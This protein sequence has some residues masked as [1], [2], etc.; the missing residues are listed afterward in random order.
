MKNGKLEELD[1]HRVGT[2]NPSA[3]P[4]GTT[5]IAAKSSRRPFT[6]GDDKVLWKWVK[7]AET[8]GLSTK[9]NEIYKSLADEVL[10]CL[11]SLLKRPQS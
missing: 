8:K 9:G 2:M 1:D 7:T 6:S 10:L 4:I 11:L 5:S 3:R